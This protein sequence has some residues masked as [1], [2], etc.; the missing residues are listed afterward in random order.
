MFS[1]DIGEEIKGEN[2]ITSPLL[3]SVKDKI[4]N[5]KDKA[6]VKKSSL[7]KTKSSA[8]NAKKG[9]KKKKAKGNEFNIP[10]AIPDQVEKPL[11]LFLPDRGQMQ[12]MIVRAMEMKDD[13]YPEF[14]QIR[15]WIEQSQPLNADLDIEC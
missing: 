3:D 7:V 2:D 14:E 13:V 8:N 1:D 6:V 10:K 11:H 4:R 5:P 12:R 9:G 15:P